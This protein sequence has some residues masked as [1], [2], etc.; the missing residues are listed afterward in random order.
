LNYS[1]K[2]EIENA[3]VKGIV[4]VVCATSTLAVGVNLPAYLVII[5]GTSQYNF[6]T[7]QMSEYSE[8]DIIQMIGRAGRPQVSCLIKKFEREAVAVI[9][10]SSN[11][12]EKYVN[13]ISGKELIE[14]H[15][16]LSLIEHLNAEIVL[17]TINS[18]KTAM[19]WLKS[20]FL[21]SLFN[22]I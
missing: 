16:H 4:K 11:K 18:E 1:D 6:Q 10:T 12:R 7:A 21:Y 22:L 2:R 3:F 17:G 8:L 15:L 5:K 13:L 14:S 19:E 9:M 20:T